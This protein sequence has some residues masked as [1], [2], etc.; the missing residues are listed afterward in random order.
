MIVRTLPLQ[1]ARSPYQSTYRLSPGSTSNSSVC[2]LGKV[3][4]L[5][6]LSSPWETQV[7][8]LTPG[9]AFGHCGLL[10]NQ[11]LI[12]RSFCLYLF[13]CIQQLLDADWCEDMQLP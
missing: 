6:S 13:F 12:C 1:K 4:Y 9:L 5:R 8:F 11:Q 7:E 2:T 3:T 10:G